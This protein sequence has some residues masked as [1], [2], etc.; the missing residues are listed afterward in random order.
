MDLLDRTFAESQQNKEILTPNIDIFQIRAINISIQSHMRN[1]M[2]K[3]NKQCFTGGM[4]HRCRNFRY[5][6]LKIHALI[7][8]K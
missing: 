5:M 4:N 6:I 1:H 2:H 8:G 7:V 3:W